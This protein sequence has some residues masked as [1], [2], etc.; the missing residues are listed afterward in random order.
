PARHRGARG[1]RR[2]G[3]RDRAGA[4]RRL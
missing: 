1:A 2:R 3:G 4:H